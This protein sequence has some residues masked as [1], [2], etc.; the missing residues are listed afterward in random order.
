MIKQDNDP[1][2]LSTWYSPSHHHHH[3]IIFILLLFII[4]FLNTF[5]TE[6]LLDCEPTSSPNQTSHE[7]GGQ[8]QAS[9]PPR[10]VPRRGL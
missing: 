3:P 2:L 10:S 8:L 9:T 5:G 1:G 4:I 7:E 6:V